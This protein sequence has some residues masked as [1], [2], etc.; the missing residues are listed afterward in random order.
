MLDHPIA[1][2]LHG[3]SDVLAPG[4]LTILPATARDIPTI[5]RFNQALAAA[6]DMA[7]LDSGLRSGAQAQLLHPQL[8]R[9][10]LA[11]EGTNPVGRLR[12][13]RGFFDFEARWALWLDNIW[14]RHESRG[15]GVLR[16]L[17][18]YVR[19]LAR[20]ENV[21]LLRLHVAKTNP[22]AQSAYRSLGFVRMET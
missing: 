3:H 19:V 13:W 8:G 20:K 6:L 15:R 2:G 7:P 9:Y 14:V 21:C 10:W 18:N 16:H 4:A 1:N 5:V 17:I 22:V 11:W 12:A